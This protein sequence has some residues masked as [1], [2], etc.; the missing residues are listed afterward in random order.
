MLI[1]FCFP[2]PVFISFIWNP[3][4]AVFPLFSFLF[5][6]EKFP[7]LIKTQKVITKKMTNPQTSRFAFS[8]FPL[9]QSKQA[10]KTVKNALLIPNAPQIGLQSTL[11]IRHNFTNFVRW[12]RT[13]FSSVDGTAPSNVGENNSS[14]FSF[15]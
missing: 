3:F 10:C 15:Q 6:V 5:S 13:E 9:T 4:S 12:C 1:T 14:Y 11:A 2:E 8:S 7:Y